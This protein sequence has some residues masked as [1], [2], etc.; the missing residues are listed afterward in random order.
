VL[1][2]GIKAPSLAQTQSSVQYPQ[3]KV[4]NGTWYLDLQYIYD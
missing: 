4:R 1:S 2:E 3:L